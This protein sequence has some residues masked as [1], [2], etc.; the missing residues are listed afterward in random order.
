MVGPSVEKSKPSKEVEMPQQRIQH[1]KKIDDESRTM[2]A[3][4]KEANVSEQRMMEQAKLKLA[5]R[6][7]KSARST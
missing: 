3:I 7:I 6:E 1:E 2:T 5:L 4:S